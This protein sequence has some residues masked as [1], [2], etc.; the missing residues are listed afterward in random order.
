VAAAALSSSGGRGV[1]RELPEMESSSS[2]VMVDVCD[3]YYFSQVD[4][5]K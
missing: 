5:V 4:V 1:S 2:M 3:Y